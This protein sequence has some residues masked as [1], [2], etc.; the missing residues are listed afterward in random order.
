MKKIG[1]KILPVFYWII[2]VYAIIKSLEI[3]N[4]LFKT[5]ISSLIGLTIIAMLGYY[6]QKKINDWLEANFSS[7]YNIFNIKEVKQPEWI[8]NFQKLTIG[9]AVTC[10]WA[11]LGGIDLTTD[12]IS[13]KLMNIKIKE[14]IRFMDISVFVIYIGVLPQF[15]WGFNYGLKDKLKKNK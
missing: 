2:A 3:A 11:S 13:N 5:S 4:T 9:I 14:D 10:F 12:L 6:S 8:K 7:I 1:Y 15:L